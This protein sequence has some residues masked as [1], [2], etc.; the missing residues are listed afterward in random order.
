MA[1]TVLL[2]G[3]RSGKSRI[4][5]DLAAAT[6]SPTTFIAT[7]EALDADLASRIAGHRGERP[8]GWTTIEEPIELEAALA[9]TGG[10]VTVLIDCLTLWVSNLLGAGTADEEVLRAAGR[11]ARLA[12]QRPGAAIVVSNEVGSGIVPASEGSRRYR[13]LLGRVGS[14]FVEQ[15]DAAYL[16]VA[17]RLL[18]LE[19]PEAALEGTRASI[20]GANSNTIAIANSDAG[21]CPDASS[22]AGAAEA[23]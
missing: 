2:G 9:S 4:A 16:V 15:A 22:R 5:L 11:V 21:A 19:R 23:R 10:R 1:L 13:D 8:A 12:G 18:S 7:A 14:I 6:K 20:A 17:G 3:A